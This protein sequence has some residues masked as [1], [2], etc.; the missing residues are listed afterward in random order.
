[1]TASGFAE[2][3]ATADVQVDATTR[4]DAQVQVG[5]AA[6]SVTVTAESPLLKVESGGR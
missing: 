5:I 6:S 2:F 3:A 4:V 1:M